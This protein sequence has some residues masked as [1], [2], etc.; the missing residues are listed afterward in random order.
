MNDGYRPVDR[1]GDD[2]PTTSAFIPP[3]DW[4]QLENEWIICYSRPG[5]FNTFR[6]HCSLQAATGRMF[7]HASETGPEGEPLRDN[8][9][10]LGLQLTNYA[11]GDRCKSDTWEGEPA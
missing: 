10:V 7:V 5:A 11:D 6:L 3:R 9:Q 1:K 8:I 4:R 2:L